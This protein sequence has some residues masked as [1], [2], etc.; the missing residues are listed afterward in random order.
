MKK[1]HHYEIKIF[2][3]KRNE[4]NN[5]LYEKVDDD[6]KREKLLD[7]LKWLTHEINHFEENSNIDLLVDEFNWVISNFNNELRLTHDGKFKYFNFNL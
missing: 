6:S 5:Y 2:M 7:Q 3:E 4:L 1:N